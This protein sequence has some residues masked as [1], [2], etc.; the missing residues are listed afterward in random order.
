M[1]RVDKEVWIE[2]PLDK[3]FDY[4]SYPNNMPEFWPS[5]VEITDLQTLRNGGYRARWVYKMLGLRFEGKAE[6]TRVAP[7]EFFVIETKGGIKSTIVWTFRSREDKTRVTF[8][9]D[10]KVPIPLLGK[11]AEVIITKMND[12]EGD[13]IMANLQTRFMTADQ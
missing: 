9:V 7:N 5:L 4:V 3:I 2:A 12:H 13:L 8:T 10:Y 6:Y 11:L 1:A